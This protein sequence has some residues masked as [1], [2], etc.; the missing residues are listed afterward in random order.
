MQNWK[1]VNRWRVVYW[2][3]NKYTTWC[4]S[5][6]EMEVRASMEQCPAHAYLQRHWVSTEHWWKGEQ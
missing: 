1:P 5:E 2:D 4:E 6:D 3:G